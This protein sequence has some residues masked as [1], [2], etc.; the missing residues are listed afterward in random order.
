MSILCTG[1][2]HWNHDLMAKLRGFDSTKA[3]DEFITEKWN[4]QVKPK[5]TV[6]HLG[7][8]AFGKQKEIT[9]IRGKLKGKIDLVLG[10][11]DYR[12]NIHK[13]GHIFTGIS[14]LKTIK[15]HHQKIILCHY[16]MLVWSSSHH[17]SYHLFSHSHGG[18]KPLFD[19]YPELI[20]K[21]FDIGWDCWQRLLDIDEVMEIFEKL[22]DNFN[23]IK[24]EE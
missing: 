4:S 14:D 22:P 23:L 2:T 17:N 18:L 1:C 7:D 16:K 9:K 6:Y 8:F 5:D 21:S 24:K 11:H 12:N 20:G 15:Y 13:L 3:M 10:N 19:K